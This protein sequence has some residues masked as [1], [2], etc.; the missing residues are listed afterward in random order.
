M[1]FA[2]GFC[3]LMV[4]VSVWLGNSCVETRSWGWL[5]VD[6][7]NVV[8]WSAHALSAAREYFRSEP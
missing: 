7:W 3:V 5:V 2:F 4:A 6:C 8:C 1:S